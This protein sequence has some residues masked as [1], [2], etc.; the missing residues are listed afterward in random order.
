MPADNKFDVRNIER[1]LRNKKISK[2]EYETYLST[3]EDYSDA[4]EECETRFTHRALE[5]SEKDEEQKEEEE[6]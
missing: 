4:V 6:E 5:D 1:N 2:E 3:L